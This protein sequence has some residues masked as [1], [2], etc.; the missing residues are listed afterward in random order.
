MA[1]APTERG[2]TEHL[3]ID[4]F[5]G[6]RSAASESTAGFTKFTVGWGALDEGA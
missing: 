1:L 2:P 3:G 4:G 5:V 6:T